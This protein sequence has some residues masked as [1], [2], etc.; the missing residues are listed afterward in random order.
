MTG[1]QI[2]LAA[3]SL[4]VALLLGGIWAF[5]TYGIYRFD[6]TAQSPEAFGL[7]GVKVVAFTS[8]DGAP[9]Q[10]WLS[11]P[12]PGKLMLFSFYGN[13][14]AIGP[15]MRRLAPLMA[16]GTGIVMLHY[17]GGGGMRGYPS[18]EN[19]ARDARALYDQLDVLAGQTIAQSRRALHGFS[20]GVGVGS[21]LASERPFA[22]VVL[23]ASFP[24][25]CVYYQRRYGGLPFCA[26]MWAERYDVIERIGQISAPKLFVHGTADM[27]VPLAWGQ[28]LFAAAPDPKTFVDLPGGGHANLAAHGLIG[29]MKDFLDKQVE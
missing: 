29:V 14:S 5:Q 16:D 28:Q 25:V 17:R 8:E 23:E 2:S 10:A 6:Q 11:M 7:T 22:A 9:V 18:E 15:S 21:R 1:F 27:D 19:F 3:F 20:L 13:F 4:A 24:R 12:A 26:L